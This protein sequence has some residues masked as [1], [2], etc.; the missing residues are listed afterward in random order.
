MTL[1]TTIDREYFSGDG[2]NKNF[3]FNF[4]F[5]NNSE[6]YVFVINE[7]GQYVQKNLDV[8]FTLS[9]AKQPG[10]GQVVFLVA[11][12]LASPGLDN[13]LIQRVLQV[14]QPTS[15]R[16]Q[17]AFFPAIHEDVFDRLTM[18]IQQ[19]IS[20]VGRALQL[21]KDGLS[22][23]FMGLRGINVGDPINSGDAANR[24]YVDDG[25]TE[26]RTETAGAIAA[27]ATIRANADAAEIAARAAADANL[28][29]QFTGNVP[30]AASAFSE[31]SWHGQSVNISVSIPD[32]KNA[33]SFGP[34]MAIAP[35]QVVTIGA[36]SFWTIAE[37]GQFV[38]YGDFS[39]FQAATNSRLTTLETT[40]LP[41]STFTSFQ[42]STNAAL[43]TKVDKPLNGLET[44]LF[45][46]S[47]T[48]Q[49]LY[50]PAMVS[51][52]GLNI[53]TNAAV[54]GAAMSMITAQITAGTTAGAKVINI[55]AGINDYF[56]S[57]PLGTIADATSG[58]SANTFYKHTWSAL[59]AAMT[60]A[61]MAKIFLISPMKSTYN[62]SSF[63]YPAANLVGVTLD[64]YRVAMR[65]VADLMGAS[66]IDMFAKSHLTT[67][68][69]TTYTSD[70]I[71]PNA[72]GAPVVGKSLG[73]LL[74]AG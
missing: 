44:S 67:Y 35:G 53:V 66:F 51:A 61:P 47:I 5:F 46:D 57:V 2:A 9:G 40:Y 72:T 32:A 22:W 68:N 25:D 11:P 12:P 4:K 26:V 8:D 7:L 64:Q 69:M 62:P 36:G 28:Q 39:T 63:T 71:H 20:G 13:V 30:L 14:D 31:I 10:G 16:N 41:T 17:G 38:S 73:I 1:T 6:I 54:S 15:I 42:S 24:K 59:N 52:T 74:N 55:W 49:A 43:A 34:N 45:G 29:A 70:T 3:P 50:I 27:E 23:D 18:L 48:A 56:Y 60:L 19:A 65:T 33:W 58:S 21:T 37:S